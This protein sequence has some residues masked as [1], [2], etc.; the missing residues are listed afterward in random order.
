MIAGIGCDL[1][2]IDRWNNEA[3]RNRIMLRWFDP[4]ERDYVN[5][6]GK[7]AGASAAGIFA[8]KEAL[9]K[10]LGCGIGPVRLEEIAVLHTPQGAPCYELRGDTLALCRQMGIRRL[11]LSI[12]HD[13]G[14]AMAF[15]VAE[16]DPCKEE[17][18]PDL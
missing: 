3:M 17:P 16:K 4:R 1:S 11:H 18:C 9:A 5:G 10:A 8:A 15:C 6:R 14:Q 12:S 7:M 2:A 13:G